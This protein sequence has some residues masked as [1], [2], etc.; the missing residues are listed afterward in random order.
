[1][2]E[3]ELRRLQELVENDQLEDALI[4]LD[5]LDH[6]MADEW[7][8]QL[9]AARH[10]I[11]VESRRQALIDG[12]A[13]VS[14]WVGDDDSWAAALAHQQNVNREQGLTILS[15]F[16]QSLPPGIAIAG[17]VVGLIIAVLLLTLPAGPIFLL[18]FGGLLAYYVYQAEEIT[19]YDRDTG[20]IYRR[21]QIFDRDHYTIRGQVTQHIEFMDELPQRLYYPPSVSALLSPPHLAQSEQ[22]HAA[23]ILQAAICSLWAWGMIGIYEITIQHAAFG[24]D[25]FFSRIQVLVP[26]PNTSSFD[27]DGELERQIMLVIER[28]TNTHHNQYAAKPWKLGPTIRELVKSL[29]S[30]STPFHSQIMETVRNDAIGRGL[31][32]RKGWRKKFEMTDDGVKAL[33]AEAHN[34]QVLTQRIAQYHPNISSRLLKTITASFENLEPKD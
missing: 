5:H 13:P 3:P 7:R 26:A 20:I 28:W 29:R 32:V 11:R 17:G 10:Q 34:V 4:Y 30:G 25:T 23:T 9:T 33:S 14:A 21:Y 6:P 8:E 15:H 22:G 18:I 16:V 1:M 24:R 12:E 31:A 2:A 19:E 27:V